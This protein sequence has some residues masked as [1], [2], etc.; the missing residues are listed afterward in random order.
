MDKIH[1][2]DC[3]KETT[4]SNG[5]HYYSKTFCKVSLYQCKSVCMEKTVG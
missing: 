5:Y 4:C 3:I 2:E 1:A